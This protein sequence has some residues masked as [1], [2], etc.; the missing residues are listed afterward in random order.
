MYPP[1]LDAFHQIYLDRSQRAIAAAEAHRQV[2]RTHRDRDL[3]SVLGRAARR[4][5]GA[6][7]RTPETHPARTS[8]A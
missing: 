5:T 7:V 2:D 6:G 4:L 1:N 8:Q 3:R